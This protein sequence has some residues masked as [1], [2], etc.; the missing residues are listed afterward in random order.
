ML[1]KSILK[2]GLSALLFYPMQNS[3]ADNANTCGKITLAD[4]NWASAE[5]AAYLDKTILEKGYDCKVSLVPSD[6]V[7][8]IT[9]MTE[10]S[11]PD[12]ASELW[13]NADRE[14]IDK[15]IADNKLKVVSNILIDGGEEGWWIP[16]YLAEKHPELKT[17]QDVLK[18]PDLFP[19]PENKKRGAFMGCP[20][21]WGCQIN[22]AN[23]FKAFKAKEAGFDLI[24]PGSAAGL[25]GSIAKAYERKQPWVGYYWAPTAILGKYP[26]YKLDFNVPYD[27]KMWD[28]CISKEGCADPKPSAW[29]KSEV[30]TVVTDDFAKKAPQAVLDYLSKRTYKND[31]LNQLLA[32][33]DDE[34]AN[35]EVGAIHFLKT[36]ETLWTQWVTPEVAAKIKANL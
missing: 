19:N 14:K 18:R 24:D 26:M 16:Q 29:T 21:G 20:S 32:W 9:S 11:E 6:T 27:Q 8:A 2:L 4:M 12:I 34:K 15:A 7:P 1:Y 25:D 33:M 5:F 22:T 35:G 36:Q 30:R 13:V 31:V 23:L 3:F 17:V 10:K 28:S